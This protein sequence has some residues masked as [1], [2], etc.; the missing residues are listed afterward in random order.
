MVYRATSSLAQ[1]QKLR[2]HLASRMS[3][4]GHS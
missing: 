3:Q 2:H 1:W 4:L